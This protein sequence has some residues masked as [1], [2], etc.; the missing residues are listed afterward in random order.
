MV[1]PLSGIAR[2]AS[3]AAKMEALM[4][5]SDQSRDIETRARPMARHDLPVVSAMIAR[6][7]AHHGD[8]P[9]V[10]PARLEADLF[11]AGPWLH[12]L[13]AERFGFIVGYALLTP[14]YRAQLT[15][16]GLDLHH[17]FV[18]EGSRG[19]GIGRLLVAAAAD[20]AR[21]RGCAFL[22]VGT[23]AE[24]VRAGDFYRANGF[25]PRVDAGP[26]FAMALG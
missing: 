16:R 25:V 5:R 3:V 10:D 24:N 8:T 9:L 14:R 19:L 4:S 22:A 2:Q 26:V 12:G 23:S 20:H 6:L 1:P 21:A 13:V 11:G 18:M 7:A 17:L 15:Q